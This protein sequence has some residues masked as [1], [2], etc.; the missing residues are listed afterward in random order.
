MTD[1]PPVRIELTT[2]RLQ[3]GCSTTEL[4]GRVAEFYAGEWR[5][6]RS[7]PYRE[8]MKMITG[9][10]VLG[11]SLSLLPVAA[12]APVAH[13]VAASDRIVTL[14][15]QE[16]KDAGFPRRPNTTAW[17]KGTAQVSP[18]KAGP[19]DPI[20]IT[21]TAPKSI[22]PGTVLMMQRFLPSNK[23]GDGTFQDLELITATVDAN[24]K[25]TLVARLARVG[26]WGY[27]VGYLTDGDNPEFIGFQFQARTTTT[28]IASASDGTT[29]DNS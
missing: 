12:L 19:D 9:A 24:R 26:L 5:M 11:I 10:A 15:R 6:P 20:T 2:Y 14:S 17:G 21:G 27:R 13:A 3:G 23:K 22:K 28:S 16:L 7:I 25:F 8:A 1:E 18:H 4:Q 29:T